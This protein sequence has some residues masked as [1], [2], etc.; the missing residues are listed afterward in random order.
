MYREAFSRSLELH[1]YAVLFSLVFWRGTASCLGLLGLRFIFSIEGV[2][3]VQCARFCFPTPRPRNA[4]GS[5][6]GQS[7]DWPLLFLVSQR[8]LIFDALCPA[9]WKLETFFIYCLFFFN[10]FFP[11]CFVLFVCLYQRINMAG[12]RI[13]SCLFVFWFSVSQK[14]PIY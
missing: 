2:C 5:K 14:V 12:S 13:L 11:F 10:S 7:Q 3:S 9:S 8:L 1:F 4:Q 6:W